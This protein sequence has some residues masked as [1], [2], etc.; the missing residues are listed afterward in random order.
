MGEDNERGL[1]RAYVISDFTFERA[2]RIPAIVLVF[3]EIEYVVKGREERHVKR[4]E[5]MRESD[6]DTKIL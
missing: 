4:A 6:R 3:G 1:G 2:R 5:T